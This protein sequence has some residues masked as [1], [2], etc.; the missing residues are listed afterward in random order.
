MSGKDFVC[1]GKP[2]AAVRATGR[3]DSPDSHAMNSETRSARLLF[4]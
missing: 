1:L 3:P 4:R 2:F